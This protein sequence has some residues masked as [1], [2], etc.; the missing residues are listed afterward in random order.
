VDYSYER[1]SVASNVS[2]KADRVWDILCR[3]GKS[4]T[5]VSVPQTFPV[6][7]LTGHLVSCFL[8]PPKAEK[9]TWPPTLRSELEEHL[10]IEHY[11]HDVLDFRTDN[12]AWLRDEIRRMTAQHFQ[13]IHYL[14]DHKP[15]DF[16]MF[17]EIGPDRIH[18]G[19]WSNMDPAHPRYVPG[20]PFESTIH[21]YYV[22]LDGEIGRVL[23]KLDD[24]TV[25]L[26]VSDHG[27]RAMQGGFCINEWLRR[28]GL[29]VLKEEPQGR[30]PVEKC[31]VDWSRTRVWGSGGYY[32]RVFFNVQGREPNGVIPQAEYASFRD[33]IVHRFE[34]TV[35]PQG[36]LL[37]TLARIPERIYREVNGI[38][39]DL[40]VYFG[41]LA[42]RSVGSLGYDSIYT[43]EN[44]TGPDDANH[45]WEGIFIAHDPQRD[46][47]GRQLSGLQLES[48]APTILR[49]LD[50][51]VPAG[52]NPNAIDLYR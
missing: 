15:W 45:D 18:H 11:T 30:V 32:A 5:V 31:Q 7:P 33:D 27:A 16:F 48:V 49:L 43:L 34:A 36:H 21:D 8:T 40:I 17:V 25:V 50:M 51:P 3:A 23:D 9:Y 10:G 52:M 29:L 28:E 26:V 12:K 42:W 46:L 44:D 39:P 47:G 20:N 4:C 1:L 13:A 24:D 37:G 22:Y 19:F 35:D 14:L 41:N 2:V 6:K 38:P